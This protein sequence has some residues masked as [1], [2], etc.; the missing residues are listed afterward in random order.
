MK[1]TTNTINYQ[2]IKNIENINR[3]YQRK[4]EYPARMRRLAEERKKAAER[5]AIILFFA[6][7][8]ARILIFAIGTIGCMATIGWADR[9]VFDYDIIYTLTFCFIIGPVMFAISFLVSEWVIKRIKDF[10][11]SNRF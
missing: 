2:D 8:I 5:K 9:V 6:P 10:V 1:Q 3:Y 7:I 11:K 4:Q